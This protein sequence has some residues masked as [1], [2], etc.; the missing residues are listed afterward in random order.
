MKKNNNIFGVEENYMIY[1]WK[2]INKVLRKKIIKFYEK[3]Q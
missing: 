1:L 2:K 3:Y